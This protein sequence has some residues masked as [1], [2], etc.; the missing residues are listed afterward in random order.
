LESIPGLNKRLK[1][2]QYC[3]SGADALRGEVLC[4]QRIVLD[5]FLKPRGLEQDI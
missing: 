5:D 3:I 4:A 2:A 1:R